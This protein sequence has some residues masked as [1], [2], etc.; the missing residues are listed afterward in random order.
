MNQM[1]NE[2]PKTPPPSR[3]SALGL[4]GAASL[5]VGGTVAIGPAAHADPSPDTRMPKGLKPGG[6]FDKLLAQLAEAD[7]F[8]G[9]VLLAH[10]GRP[11][12]TRSYGMADK[13]RSIPNGRDTLFGLASITKI[14]TALALGR[15][16]QKGDVLLHETLGT[17]LDGFSEKTKRVTIHQLLTH[18][19]GLRNYPSAPGYTD[20]LKEWDSTTE[21][22]DGVMAIIRKMESE[23]QITP[24]TGHVYSNSGYFVLGALVAQ[25]AG[26][27]Y[28]D[29]VP[30]HVL[31][32]TGMRR[33]KLYTRPEVRANR[34]I[35]HPYMTEKSGE[36]TDLTTSDYFGFVG[37]PAD[38][39]Y[40]TAPELLGFARALLD[41]EPLNPAYTALFTSG[42]VP[43][44]PTDPPSIQADSRFYAYGF[45][46]M[47]TGGHRVFGH[48]GSG[49]GRSTN[50]DIFPGLDWV[51]VVLSNYDTSIQPIVQKARDLIT[52]P[53]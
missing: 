44:T 16:V 17:Y 11:V 27:P 45:R 28:H 49:T 43:L 46:D 51:T 7:Q 6:P 36:R 24:G 13:A 34:D 3:R 37:G 8:S 40:S 32:P 26:E 15:L 47:I 38:G 39:I 20:K 19:A 18:T 14:F 31:A 5:A 29:Y 25:V 52:S 50:L 22:M 4:L 48:S 10:R 12:L 9:T 35:A 2:Y 42:K 1:R 30:Q 23:P 21:V 33:S 41:G 53:A